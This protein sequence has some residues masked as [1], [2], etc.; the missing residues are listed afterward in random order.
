MFPTLGFDLFGQKV[1]NQVLIFPST[2][3]LLNSGFKRL[4]WICAIGGYSPD[5]SVG[6]ESA[7]N[8][9]DIGDAGFGHC[10]GK[11]PWRREWRPTPVFLP[12]KSH[13]QRS[14]VG[15]NSKGCKESDVTEQLSPHVHTHML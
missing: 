11:I 13:G 10:V 12:E 5:G 15:Y 1:S 9:G 7:C 8:A 3:K 6:Q 14:L 4:E 2:P